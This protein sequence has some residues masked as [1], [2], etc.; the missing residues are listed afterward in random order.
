MAFMMNIAAYVRRKGRQ[1]DHLCDQEIKK[2]RKWSNRR[3]RKAMS[4]IVRS[5]DIDWD[6]IALPL[7]PKTEGWLTI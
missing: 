1:P 2:Y 6:G 5:R 7:P 4:V 3:H